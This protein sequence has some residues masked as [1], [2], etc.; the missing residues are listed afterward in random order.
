MPMFFSNS[1]L[2][3]P[4]LAF[5]VSNALFHEILQL[6]QLEGADLKNSTIDFKFHLQNIQIRHFWSQI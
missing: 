3:Y 4:N 6:D 5:L 2:K 1:N